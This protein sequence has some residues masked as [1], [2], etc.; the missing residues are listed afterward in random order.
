[1]ALG[2][3]LAP[4]ASLLSP[5]GNVPARGGGRRFYRHCAAGEVDGADLLARTDEIAAFVEDASARYGL[6]PQRIAAFGHSA[7]ANAALSLLLRRSALLRGACLL[8]PTYIAHVEHDPRADLRDRYVLV[9]AGD[10]DPLSSREQARQ[11]AQILRASGAR[12][13]LHCEPF[14]EHPITHGDLVCSVRWWRELTR[15]VSAA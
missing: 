13:S 1:M 7:G 6:D 15:G 12:V 4:A 9:A 3:R 14:A 5:R 11:I 10:R 2:E 8:R